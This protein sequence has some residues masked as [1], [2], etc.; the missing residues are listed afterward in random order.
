MAY[1]VENPEWVEGIH[2]L[3][4]NERVLGGADG[5]ANRQAKELAARTVYLKKQAEAAQQGMSSHLTDD[6]PHKNSAPLASP[7]FTGNPTAPTA[8]AGAN[9][10]QIATTAFVARALADLVGSAP[11]S[12]DTLRELGDALGN[13]ANF[14]ANVLD[15]ISAK[16]DKNA[17]IAIVK[18]IPSS[19]SSPAVFVEDK[20]LLMYWITSAHYTGYRSPDCGRVLHGH[21]PSPLP[22]ELD[23]KGGV[24]TQ[25]NF[26]GLVARFKESNL[27][28][29]VAQYAK[30]VYRLWD[31]GAG[32]FRLPNLE[33][34]F[35]RMTGTDLDNANARALGSHQQDALQNI[36]GR[37][38]FL[39]NGKSF[40]G[41]PEIIGAFRMD[42]NPTGNQNRFTMQSNE[43]GVF[44]HYRSAGFDASRAA[45]TSTETRSSNTALAPRIIAF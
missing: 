44:S 20:Q 23:L 37:L 29:P 16:A 4:T 19:K 25:A 39:S 35:L 42:D 1:L 11:A 10:T 45:R 2:Q 41:E 22:F 21:T 30:G 33:D 28:S 6:N 26:P 40:I 17:S 18:S 14:A 43:N 3:E 7:A 32:Q 15:Q 13:D 38:N 36:T 31:M 34:Q 9:T 27:I 12:L 24:I 8:V 5:V